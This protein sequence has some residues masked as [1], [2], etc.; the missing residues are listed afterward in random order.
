MDNSALLLSTAYFAPV[1]FYSRYLNHNKVFIEQHENFCKQTYRNRCQILAANGPIALVIP[2]VKGRGPKIVIKDL[3]I[4]YD[5]QWQRNHWQTIVSAYNS[6]PYFEF[7]Q[8]ELLPFFEKKTKY[9]FDHNLKIHE[10]IC[11]FFELENKL[12]CTQDFEQ[13][14]AATLNLRDAISPKLK[15]STDKAFVPQEYTQVFTEKYGFIP[16]LSILDLLFNEGPNAY[17]ILHKSINYLS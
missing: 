5:E 10:T 8:D 14:P 2:V 3:Q 15:N 11:D 12:I 1:H 9:L 13:I 7:Y 4:S 17:T 16:N 6:S